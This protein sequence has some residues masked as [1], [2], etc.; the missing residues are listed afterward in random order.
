MGAGPAEAER[1][2]AFIIQTESREEVEVWDQE[3]GRGE[4][5]WRRRKWRRDQPPV[6][7]R[8]RPNGPLSI[9]FPNALSRNP[10]VPLSER[11]RENKERGR[12]GRGL[13]G[14]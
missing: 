4:V 9:V 3:S 6:P 7:S 14:S 5:G 13:S 12:D 8:D 11:G 1:E 10:L 2:R